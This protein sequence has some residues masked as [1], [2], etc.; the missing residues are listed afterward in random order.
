ML[1]ST[2]GVGDAVNQNELQYIA[3]SNDHV[4][5][6]SDYTALRALKEALA[7]STCL[8]RCHVIDQH[9]SLSFR[10][11]FARQKL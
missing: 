9:S 10:F 7:Q 2:S 1:S 3:S 5:M 4:F 6:V 11:N 8:G